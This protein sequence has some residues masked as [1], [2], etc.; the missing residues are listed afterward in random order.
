MLSLGQLYTDNNTNDNDDDNDDDNGRQWHMTDKSWLHRLIGMYAK[1]AKKLA[2]NHANFLGG[3]S[4][5][6]QSFISW[7]TFNELNLFRSAIGKKYQNQNHQ[8]QI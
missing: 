8:S 5:K 7:I 2:F 3:R 1:W 4:E 6:I